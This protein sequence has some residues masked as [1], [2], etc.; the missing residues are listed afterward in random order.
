MAEPKEAA[1]SA[2]DAP[3]TKK[4]LDDKSTQILNAIK[5]GPETN[6]N[7]F[8]SLFEAFGLKDLF[9]ALKDGEDWG[10]KL[11][12]AFGAL[13][14]LVLGKLLDFGK[15]F[16]AGLEKVTRAWVNRGLTND[17]AQRPGRVLTIGESGLPQQM[18]RAR[19]DGLNA[20][21]INPH[22]LTETQ[23]NTLTTA[24]QGLSPEVREFNS[25]TRDMTSASTISKIT[26]AIGNLKEKLVP[27][28]PAD[29]IRQAAGAIDE[30]NTSMAAY[31]PE[32]L[33]KP[34]TFRA[35]AT[36]AQE[37]NREAGT[38][39]R[40]F[41]ELSQSAGSAAGAIGGSGGTPSP[42]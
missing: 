29:D 25:A 8:E 9:S 42:A 14:A 27:N 19:M 5:A 4:Q 15:I 2:P 40:T 3:A 39:K 10:S 22:G 26:K 37:L 34:Q 36:A 1:N 30:L 35:I 18:T 21:S 6:K 11:L 33:P 31:K 7:I 23:L 32:K 17:Q 41:L 20:V 38:L 16:N 28:N 13:A 24:L 12:L